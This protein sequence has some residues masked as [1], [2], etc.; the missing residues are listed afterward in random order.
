MRMS[1]KVES[2]PESPATRIKSLQMTMRVK[3]ITFLLLHK[4]FHKLE[5]YVLYERIQE[6]KN[7]V[8]QTIE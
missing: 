4:L 1:R 7:S 3:H 2:L 6:I 8:N 5:A